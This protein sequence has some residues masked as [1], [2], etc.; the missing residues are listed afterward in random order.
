MV[1][2][3]RRENVKK[4]D[5]AVRGWTKQTG[6]KRLVLLSIARASAWVSAFQTPRTSATTRSRSS[7]GDLN[8]LVVDERQQN[9]GHVEIG[10]GVPQPARRGAEDVLLLLAA[11]HGRAGAVGPGGR[12]RS[13][14]RSRRAPPSRSRR[15][16]RSGQPGARRWRLM[17]LRALRKGVISSGQPARG[18]GGAGRGRL[19]AGR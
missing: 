6:C 5:A 13:V 8:H 2:T 10:Q 17:A 7:V 3:A 1:Q 9:L 14:Q 18:V 16:A 19:R 11:L 12:P 15:S 4:P